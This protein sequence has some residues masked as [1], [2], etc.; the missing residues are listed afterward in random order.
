M[1]LATLAI[2]AGLLPVVAAIPF[3]ALA[4]RPHDFDAVVCAVEQRYNAHAQRVPMMGFVSFCAWAA[5]GGGV[6]G[7]KI[8]EFDHLSLAPARLMVRGE[9]AAPD[10]G[11]LES[12]VRSSLGPGWQPFVTDREG[13]GE[14]SVI[15]VQP[16]GGSM[17]MMIAD[18]NNHELDLVRIEING[19]RLR[20]W[21]KDPDG[22]AKR[23]DYS[24]NGNTPD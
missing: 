22:S 14:V 13:S 12:L 20:H 11:E 7:L 5:T 4:S 19:D 17:R 23:H 24:T 8:A 10:S 6:K 3:V 1:K 2:S 21:M 16:V 15:Y 18:Y 9:T